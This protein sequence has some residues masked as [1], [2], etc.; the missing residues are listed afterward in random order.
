MSPPK[1]DVSVVVCTH[2]RPIQLEGLLEG[3]VGQ[4]TRLVFEILVV[5]NDPCPVS[6]MPWLDDAALVRWMAEPRR[7]LSYARNA[8]IRAA[9]AELIALVDDDIVVSPGWLD[10]LVGPI[11][12]EGYDGVTGPMLPVKLETEA[13]RL[14][15]AFG[16]HGHKQH[17]AVFD[18]EWLARQRL[19]LPLWRIGSFGN[20]ALRKG[21]VEKLGDFEEALGVGTPTGSSEDLDY[22]Y[23]M[24][25]AGFRILHTPA[26][27]VEHHHRT[28][29]PALERQLSGYRRG[30][31]CFCLLTAKR[32]HEPRALT[33]LLLWL[34]AWHGILLAQ[35][36]RRRLRGQRLIPFSL[37]GRQLLALA[38]APRALAISLRRKRALAGTVLPPV[39]D[40]GPAPADPLDFSVVIPTRGRP[41]AL[42]Q[43]LQA[44]AGLEPGRLHFEVIVV[45]DGGADALNAVVAPWRDRLLLRL[46]RQEHAGPAR[47]RNLG[48]EVA[49]GQW[50]AF[51][52]DD[53]L[54]STTWLA[55]FAASDADPREALGG[56]TCN[57][58]P[59]NRWSTVS[60]ELVSFVCGWLLHSGH[61]LRFLPSKNFAVSAS[62]FR[63]LGGF[64]PE[65]P[66]AA[67]EDREFCHR[68]LQSGGRLRVVEAALVTHCHHL[69]PLS[70]WGQHFRYGRGAFR[71]RRLNKGTPVQM[72]PLAFYRD[73]MRLPWRTQGFSAIVRTPLLLASQA[74]SVTGFCFQALQEALG[75]TPPRRG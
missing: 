19:V 51:L 6:A 50:L 49:R 10:A 5:D 59:G 25:R 68:W 52:D 75:T 36:L 17:R 54:P 40:A 30:E 23:R 69:G 18:G 43:C 20:A 31:A 14:F 11:L 71:F 32:H 62:R 63:A 58:L 29:L 15:E 37:M 1:P 8:G 7:G 35:E 38:E 22:L 13:E 67:A 2:D 57:A 44:L 12:E 53:C 47:A 64:S 73:L 65:F 33:H 41:Q 21:V 39:F 66:L 56:V 24:L 55:A 42:R 26:A 70:F 60:H 16:G 72:L 61:T 46:L 3:I 9:N 34:P 45:D 48:A 74:A 28:E 27:T 4:R